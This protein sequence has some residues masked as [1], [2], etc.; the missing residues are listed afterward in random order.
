GLPADR[1]D[2]TRRRG[3]LS[4]RRT[5][6]QRTTTPGRNLVGRVDPPRAGGARRV[7]ATAVRSSV[8][9]SL[10]VGHDGAA[11]VHRPPGRRNSFAASQG[12]RAALRPEAR[13]PAVFFHYLRLD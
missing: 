2:R 9:Y 7:R 12:A 11:E 8:V 5:E 3:S 4:R 1:L 10:L 13:R 6:D